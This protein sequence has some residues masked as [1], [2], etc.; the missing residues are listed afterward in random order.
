MESNVIFIP[1]VFAIIGLLFML[2]KM[3]WVKKQASGSAKMQ[4]ISTAI[5]EGA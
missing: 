4:E 5:K 3:F 2:T 1:I